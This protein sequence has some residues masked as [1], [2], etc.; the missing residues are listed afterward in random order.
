M[1]NL[2]TRL[3]QLETSRRADPYSGL[4]PELWPLVGSPH[5]HEEWVTILE[6]E[7]KRN[8]P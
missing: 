3:V 8:E 1:A 5:T 4:D 7:E 6:E 2:K